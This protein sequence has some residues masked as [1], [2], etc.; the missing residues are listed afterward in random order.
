M[1]KWLMNCVI[2]WYHPLLEVPLFI[3]MTSRSFHNTHT[4]KKLH[5]SF[6]I[7][8]T[9]LILFWFSCL[10]RKIFSSACILFHF[11]DKRDHDK[12]VIYRYRSG[13]YCFI[14]YNIINLTSTSWPLL[15]SY[16]FLLKM[17]IGY[18]TFINGRRWKAEKRKMMMI[19]TSAER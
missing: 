12:N 16:C 5:E 8:A 2:L 3:E 11:T 14:I 1:T 9:S 17:V 13:F 15:P 19:L 10:E 4:K 18:K 7:S 6:P